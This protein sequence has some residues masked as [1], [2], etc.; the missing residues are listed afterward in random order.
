M[1]KDVV[2]QFRLSTREPLTNKLLY[3]ALG[4][5]REELLIDWKDFKACGLEVMVV[6]EGS[7]VNPEKRT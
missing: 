7:G 3:E 6:T 1:L 2:V 4:D 5:I